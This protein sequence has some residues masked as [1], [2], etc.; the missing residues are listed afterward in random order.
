ME[1][2]TGQK[3]NSNAKSGEKRNVV[4]DLIS[5]LE[6]SHLVKILDFE[7]VEEELEDI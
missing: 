1:L 2:M 6:N 5:S 4:Q 7:A 3:P